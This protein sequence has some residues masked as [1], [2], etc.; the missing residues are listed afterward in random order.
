MGLTS[1]KIDGVNS[2]FLRDDRFR[3]LVGKGLNTTIGVMSGCSTLFRRLSGDING[4]LLKVINNGSGM[5]N[6]FG[7]TGCGLAS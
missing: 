6:L 3:S 1:T 2:T 7:F 4:A 5:T